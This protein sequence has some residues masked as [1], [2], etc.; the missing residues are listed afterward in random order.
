MDYTNVY[1]C[2]YILIRS[3]HLGVFLSNKKI[4]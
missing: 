3:S 4:V 2:A 1:I